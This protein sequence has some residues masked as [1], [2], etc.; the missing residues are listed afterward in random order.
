M[1]EWGDPLALKPTSFKFF[2][3]WAGHAEFKTIVQ[4]VWNNQIEGSMMFQIC[5]KLQLLRAPLRKLNR[6]HFAQIDRREVEVREQLE[7][8][9]NELVLRPFDTALHLAEKDLTR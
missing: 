9:K 2:N 8:V 1:I 5:R 3:M 4:N 6:L 7:M